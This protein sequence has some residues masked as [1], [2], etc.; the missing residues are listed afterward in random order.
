[1]AH[2]QDYAEPGTREI[3]ALVGGSPIWDSMFGP[4]RVDYAL[5]FAKQPYAVSQRLQFTAGAW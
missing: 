3:C 4:L 1:M 2:A 5:P